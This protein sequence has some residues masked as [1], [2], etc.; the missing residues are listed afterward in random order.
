MTDTRETRIT[1]PDTLR[2]LHDLDAWTTAHSI[3]AWRDMPPTYDLA[4]S[5]V[6]RALKTIY[7]KTGQDYI[8]DMLTGCNA[9]RRAYA[10]HN[11]TLTPDVTDLVQ[12]AIARLLELLPD[13]ATADET[14]QKI[15]QDRY[16]VQ[17][18]TESLSEY[19]IR[20]WREM[21]KAVNRQV[22]NSAA[23]KG[24]CRVTVKQQR[25]E[26]PVTVIGA[27]GER[28]EY[29]PM[30]G[31]KPR[32]VVL[33]SQSSYKAEFISLD[34]LTERPEDFDRLQHIAGNDCLEDD[35]A[36]VALVQACRSKEAGLDDLTASI[37]IYIAQGYTDRD[38]AAI[39]HIGKSS[40]A[41][42]IAKARAKLA[43]LDCYAD[44]AQVKAYRERH[45]P[46]AEK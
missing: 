11:T 22:H 17:T 12:T 39:L 43:A 40:V 46:A 16:D 36:R 3:T 30:D 42:R 27:D 26:T 34:S 29:T 13:H 31:A 19:T 7:N 1:R 45:A 15:M 37:T 38:I 9:Y 33:D 28:R 6:Q 24:R 35:F 10:T 25:D 44:S 14:A 32:A 21:L 41:R 23:N 8:R 2:D 4:L 20:T 18:G 5:A